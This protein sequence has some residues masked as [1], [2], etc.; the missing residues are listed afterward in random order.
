VLV[1]EFG[2]SPFA[3]D[4]EHLRA[5]LHAGLWGSVGIPLGGAPMFWWWMAIDEENLYP[6]FRGPARF[7]A[8]VDRRDPELLPFDPAFSGAAVPVGELAWTCLRSPIQALGWVCRVP[9]FQ[10]LD[11]AG[12]ARV[13]DLKVE[14]PGLT[15][16][17]FTVEY[18]DTVKG[19]VA[20]RQRI[21][22]TNGLLTLTLPPFVR[23]A[24]FKARLAGP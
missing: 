14:L 11:L 21:A 18:W 2:G 9:E 12:P 22:T 1:T 17:A 20:A 5:T 16:G 8:D 23:D 6:L 13:Q 7:M 19:E 4:M 3:S 24:A 10:T 15:N